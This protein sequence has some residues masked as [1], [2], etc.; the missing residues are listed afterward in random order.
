MTDTGQTTYPINTADTDKFKTN[1]AGAGDEGKIP[2]LNSSGK[3]DSS[4]DSLNIKTLTAGET[5]AGA[6]LPVAVYQSASDNKIYACDGNDIDKLEFIGFAITTTTGADE[7]ITIQTNGIVSGFSG[8]TEGTKYYVQDAVGTIGT[9]IGT[10]ERLVGIAISET[11]LL[12]MHGSEE[13]LGSEA[14]NANTSGTTSVDTVTMPTNARKAI[15]YVAKF[16]HTSYV[17]QCVLIIK[18]KGI[19]TAN[20]TDRYESYANNKVSAVLSADTIT[21]TATTSL[22]GN[23]TD[24]QGTAYFYT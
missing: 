4:F 6:T 12:I 24:I 8:L 23:Y 5:I 14:F 17:S 19:T 11:E 21:I 10:Y 22:S 7:N 3:L 1:S 2:L 18:R 9:T 13:Y 16:G 20:T 15:I